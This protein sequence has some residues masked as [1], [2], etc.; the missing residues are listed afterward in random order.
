MVGGEGEVREGTR[1]GIPSCVCA[2]VGVTEGVLR[3]GTIHV[4]L[5]S[6]LS[7]QKCSF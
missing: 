1:E 7:V 4:M 2:V 6:L 3:C 5:H